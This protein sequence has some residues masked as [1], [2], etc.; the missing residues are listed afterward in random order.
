MTERREG[1]L[2]SV[3]ALASCGLTITAIPL[4]GHG[5]AT[6]AGPGAAPDK[7]VMLLDFH[8]FRADQLLAGGARAASLVLVVVV[9]FFL[10]RA[11]RR[12]NPAYGRAVPIICV[13][14]CAALVASTLLGFVALDHLAAQFATSGVQSARRATRLLDGSGVMRVIAVVDLLAEVVLGAWTVAASYGALRAGLLTRSLAGIG[15]VAGLM[16]AITLPSG[17]ALFIAWLCGIGVL[18]LGYWPGG[19]PAAWREEVSPA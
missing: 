16:S 15:I 18:A 11:T 19:R 3:A 5:A 7:A 1:V 6:V 12:R 2:A 9:A 4:S 14:A 17:P 13:V 10:F 8:R